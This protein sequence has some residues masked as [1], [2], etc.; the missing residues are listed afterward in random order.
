MIRVFIRPTWTHLVA[1]GLCNIIFLEQFRRIQITK[2]NSL[3]VH[4]GR[5]F[6]IITASTTLR[7]FNTPIQL[8]A[9]T[10]WVDPRTKLALE[11][12]KFKRGPN[13]HLQP[14]SPTTTNPKLNIII[15]PSTYLGISF[16]KVSQISEISPRGLSV[17]IY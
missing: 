14:T 8:P 12:L 9:W 7:V 5:F 13:Q 6:A 3:H 4:N 1:Q 16:R 10:V 11:Y 2:S 15:Y 17:S